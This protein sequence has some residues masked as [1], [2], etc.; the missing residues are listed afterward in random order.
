M[1]TGLTVYRFTDVIE[2]SVTACTKVTIS[3]RWDIFGPT[4]KCIFAKDRAKG[5]SLI[6]LCIIL[7]SQE[8]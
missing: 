6:S 2:F 1:N 7:D 8:L 3:Q 4:E 5:N